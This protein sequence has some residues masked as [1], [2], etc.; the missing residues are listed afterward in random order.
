MSFTALNL[1][2]MPLARQ[3]RRAPVLWPCCPHMHAK[4]VA[5]EGET[6]TLC[7]RPLRS[8]VAL[9]SRYLKPLPETPS[10]R[11][12]A[13]IDPAFARRFAADWI[14][15]WNRH[16]LDAILAHYTDD[17]EMRSPLIAQ[18][19]GEPSGRLGGKA[20][21]GAYWATALQRLPDLRFTLLDVLV[22]VDSLLLHY[23][24]PRG[25][26]AECFE[27]GDDGRVIRAAAHYVV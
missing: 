4:Y 3:L 11:N 25:P 6:G 19:A 16:D 1:T 8:L 14:D 15:A 24:G 18:F 17:F 27:F 22:G 5:R 20:A 9:S 10:H 21:V 13:V 2:P 12:H 7:I 23:R 26:A